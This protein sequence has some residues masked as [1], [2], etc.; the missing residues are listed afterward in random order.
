LFNTCGYNAL[1]KILTSF[2]TGEKIENVAI[3][4]SAGNDFLQ[5]S[6]KFLRAMDS[7]DI[8]KGSVSS[9]SVYLH[10]FLSRIFACPINLQKSILEYFFSAYEV[11]STNLQENN[12]DKCN[13]EEYELNASNIMR[14]SI[15]ILNSDKKRQIIL[16]SFAQR[17]NTNIHVISGSIMVAI[18]KAGAFF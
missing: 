17:N 7:L 8:P 5:E 2:R 3:P 11:E 15:E 1:I 16:N 4:E 6:A 13:F 9:T 10:T 12:S 18:I 14:E